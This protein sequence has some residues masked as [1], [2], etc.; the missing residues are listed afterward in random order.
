MPRATG[1]AR[2]RRLDTLLFDVT[3]TLMKVRGSVGE[4][5]AR[6]GSGHG[7]RLDPERV[8]R[9]FERAR[10]NAPPLA[11]ATRSGAPRRT[12]ER[13]WWRNVLR[14]T[15]QGAGQT[16][17]EAFFDD[18]Y[19]QFAEEA[20]WELDPDG[21][22]VLAELRRRGYVLGVLSNFDSRLPGLLGALGLASL[23]AAVET[24]SSLGVAKPHPQ[25]FHGALAALGGSTAS[26]AY[27]GDSPVTDAGGAAAAGLLPV[28]LRASLPPGVEGLTIGGLIELLDVFPGP[29]HERI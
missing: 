15:L 3:G 12:A 7:V 14:E 18:V 21:P 5:Y 10:R 24:S 22:E 2:A 19:N 16:A 9:S 20:A 8:N 17:P 1:G 25:A 29:I 23:F 27:I 26:A 4:I 6:R 13:G 11:F 28:L